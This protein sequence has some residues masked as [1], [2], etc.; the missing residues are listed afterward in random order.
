MT[1]PEWTTHPATLAAAAWIVSRMQIVI[2]VRRRV[3]T[4]FHLWKYL[5]LRW[6]QIL[7]SLGSTV[8][9]YVLL[10]ATDSLDTLNAIMAGAAADQII[11]RFAGVLAR[12]ARP[13]VPPGEAPGDVTVLVRELSDDTP[14]DGTANDD[15]TQP[16]G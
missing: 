15:P 4:S 13:E 7:G 9:A 3:G 14:T 8:G 2:E 10:V 6:R 11:D 1:L 16:R 12:R 5:G